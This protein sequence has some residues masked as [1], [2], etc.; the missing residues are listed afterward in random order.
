MLS[1]E[2]VISIVALIDRAYSSGDSVMRQ[3]RA[4]AI[5]L[6][7]MLRANHWLWVVSKG[8][9]T[10]PTALWMLH[11]DLT[12]TQLANVYK[13]TYATDYPPPENPELMR[14]LALGRPFTRRR[15]DLVESEVWRSS[16]HYKRYRAAH[17][18][19]EFVY[20]VYPLPGEIF[21]ALGFHREPGREPFSTRERRIAHIVMTGVRSLHENGVPGERGEE[22]PA[23]TPRLRTV[24]GLM[25]TGWRRKRIAEHLDLSGNTVAEYQKKIY[26]HF[27]VTSQAELQARFTLGDGGDVPP[28]QANDSTAG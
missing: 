28:D 2:D 11:S 16:A 9:S 21:S 24:L 3:R 14:E 15:Q 10:G 12:D 19:D 8:T 27:N 26:R 7:E 5:G 17:G 23:L 13:G 18:F 25:L 22:V 4:L 20:A 6:A 1:E